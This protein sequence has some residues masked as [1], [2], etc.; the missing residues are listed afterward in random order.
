MTK[1]KKLAL[2]IGVIFM[3]NL[4]GCKGF[5]KYAKYESK[6]PELGI[7]VDYPQGWIYKDSRDPKGKFGQVLFIEDK[8]GDFLK[9]S[10]WILATTDPKIEAKPATVDSLASERIAKRLNYKDSR[11]VSD[12]PIVIDGGKGRDIVFSYKT[13][14]K[15]QSFGAGLLLAKERTVIFKRKDRFFIISYENAEK[16]FRQF[17]PAFSHMLKSIKFTEVK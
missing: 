14:E 16:N 5:F 17:D 13:F 7:T 11:L 4:A 15:I 8:K 9:G 6:F 12:S 2:I 1:V 3:A 10:F